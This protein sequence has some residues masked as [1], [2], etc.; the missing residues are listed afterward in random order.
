MLQIQ[1]PFPMMQCESDR[2]WAGEHRLPEEPE[3]DRGE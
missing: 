3:E 1:I 2:V